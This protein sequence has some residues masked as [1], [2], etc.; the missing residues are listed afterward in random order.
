MSDLYLPVPNRRIHAYLHGSID[1]R[2]NFTMQRHAYQ[3]HLQTAT[4]ASD[5]LRCKNTALGGKRRQRL[6]SRMGRTAGLLCFCIYHVTCHDAASC[7]CLSCQGAISREQP[8]SSS[9]THGIEKSR[10]L[11][12]V[13]TD[14]TTGPR[15]VVIHI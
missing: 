1:H 3:C 10:K 9:D 13:G 8:S 4:P 5:A 12:F 2:H 11:E 7:F 6:P 14:R 15:S